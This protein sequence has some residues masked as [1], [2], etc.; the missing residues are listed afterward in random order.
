MTLR[1]T[2]SMPQPKISMYA[3]STKP[4]FKAESAEKTD[5]TDE[6][7]SSKDDT[8]TDSTVSEDTSVDKTDE[9][10]ESEKTDETDK[11]DKT[12][13]TDDTNE[14]ADKKADEKPKE[15]TTFFGSLKARAKEKYEEYKKSFLDFWSTTKGKIITVAS[16][17][18]AGVVIF[19]VRNKVIAEKM[20]RK[21]FKELFTD[22]E[23]TI[24]AGKT[25]FENISDLFG[26]LM[27][28][29][30]DEISEI[31]RVAGEIKDD[32]INFITRLFYKA[33]AAADDAAEAA[34]E[35]ASEAVGGG[36]IKEAI[37]NLTEQIVGQKEA[38]Q[39]GLEQQGEKIAQLTQTIDESLKAL[40][41]I[42]S[43]LVEVVENKSKYGDD[44]YKPVV[45]LAKLFN[46]AKDIKEP[47]KKLA[48]FAKISTAVSKALNKSTK[49]LE[50]AVI[51]IPP[52]TKSLN[53]NAVEI[54]DE[55]IKVK[56]SKNLK[57][58]K[59]VDSTRKAEKFKKPENSTA[60]SISPEQK[61]K[62]ETN[63][64]KLK[65]IH[66][67]KEESTK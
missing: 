31:P 12:D 20:S 8:N 55:T 62:K 11:T 61:N 4:S 40:T 24:E 3:L 41:E 22:H 57:S 19:G 50:Q 18:A 42:Q 5:K 15:E 27:S 10:N 26:R 48:V 14:D 6:F 28:F 45:E 52:E 36:A 44:V 7:V 17:I 25:L 67:K 35:G 65:R 23:E 34:A 49:E 64:D 53:P 33:R 54:A 37:E 60:E 2:T 63:L 46:E 13:K 43:K 9:T 47:E 29:S 59:N 21:N 51:T 39:Q 58:A 66:A 32:C 38:V 56:L 16:V 30:T 1:L